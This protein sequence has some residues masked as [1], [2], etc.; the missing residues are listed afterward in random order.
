MTSERVASVSCAFSENMEIRTFEQTVS[1]VCLLTTLPAAK[2]YVAYEETKGRKLMNMRFKILIP[3][4]LMG[5]TLYAQS[6]KWE[7]VGWVGGSVVA[8]GVFDYFGHNLIMTQNHDSKS[9]AIVYRTLQLAV[10]MALSYML[11]EK[12]GLPEAV[13]FN[14]VW[15]TFGADFVYYGVGELTDGFGNPEWGR[16]GSWDHIAGKGG[17]PWAYWTPVGIAR[18]FDRNE[19]ISADTII[20]QAITGAM[21]SVAITLYF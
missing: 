2:T 10:Q 7:E 5:T 1:R 9:S 12:F 20:A 8:F 15:W 13:A 11:Y 19:R 6:S 14:L 3:A 18:G 16:R 17:P 4:L 21:L